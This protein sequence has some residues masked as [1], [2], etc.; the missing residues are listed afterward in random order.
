MAWPL[1]FEIPRYRNVFRIESNQP[2]H[3]SSENTNY[4]SHGERK[5]HAKTEA[6]PEEVKGEDAKLESLKGEP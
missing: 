6:G 3:L 2:N 4:E 5:I 1:H